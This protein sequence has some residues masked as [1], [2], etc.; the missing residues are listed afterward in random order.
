MRKRARVTGLSFLWVVW[1]AQLGGCQAERQGSE[2]ASEDGQP[3]AQPDVME[4]KKPTCDGY[5]LQVAADEELETIAREALAELAPEA[6][7]SW[8]VARGAPTGVEM[9]GLDVA[10]PEGKD[11]GAAL[12]G[13]FGAW[14]KVFRLSPL[15]WDI[16]QVQC[17]RLSEGLTILPLRRRELAGLPSVENMAVLLHRTGKETVRVDR[18]I[19]HYTG[20]LSRETLDAMASCPPMDE[21]AATDATLGNLYGFT[22]F[23]TCAPI[24]GGTY[25]PS[26]QDGVSFSTQRWHIGESS[27]GLIVTRR[28]TAALLV[29]PEN[30][31][32]E[33]SSSD[34]NCPWG[35]VGFEAE[36]DAVGAKVLGT[37][38]GIGPCVVCA[39]GA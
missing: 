4:S 5:P 33:L 19:G 26:E 21:K 3:V 25:K 27:G 22:T 15:E 17:D 37:K 39:A 38:P 35:T 36:L 10:C 24:G 1:S 34:A 16:A 20:E 30:V 12:L 18:V 2:P 31:T 9:L 8:S 13:A 7:L 6:T 28:V 14:P 32:P 29:A 11:V 23:S